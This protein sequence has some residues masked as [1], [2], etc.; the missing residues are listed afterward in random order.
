[1]RRLIACAFLMLAAMPAARA[2]CDGEDPGLEPAIAAKKEL[3]EAKNAQIVRDLRTL[4]H[5]AIVLESY[6]YPDECKRLVAIVKG[7]AAKPDE[8]IKRSSDTDE[9]KAE[10]LQFSGTSGSNGEFLLSGLAPG[11]YRL[12]VEGRAREASDAPGL[13]VNAGDVDVRVV[14]PRPAI[15]RGTVKRDGV[16]VT[17]LTIDEEPV[18]ARDGRFVFELAPEGDGEITLRG[19]FVPVTLAVTHKPGIETDLGV[20]D[21]TPLGAIEGRIAN[22]TAEGR[23][24][25]GPSAGASKLIAAGQ[26]NVDERGRFHVPHRA[27]RRYI[28]AVNTDRGE[29]VRECEVRAGRTTTLDFAVPRGATLVDSERP[30]HK[31][32]HILEAAGR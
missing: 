24:F 16:P 6:G 1:M 30:I 25:V 32:D 26:F 7:L 23:V 19:D 2:E 12:T 14:V 27:P 8:T 9:E 31:H 10:E 20:I 29:V 28:V 5:A 18:L 22:V 21:V 17:R 11:R 15:I 13:I 3:Q 4:R